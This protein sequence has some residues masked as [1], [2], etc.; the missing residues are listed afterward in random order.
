MAA[1]HKFNF[2]SEPDDSLKCL[3]CSKVADEEPWQHDKCGS[4]FCKKCLDKHGKDKRCP[5]CRAE[6]PQYF[7]DTR[8]M[9]RL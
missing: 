5:N 6:Q 1:A 7:E 3:V 8:G 2:V 4:L 9:C